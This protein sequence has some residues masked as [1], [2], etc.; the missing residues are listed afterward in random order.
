MQS[1]IVIYEN[2]SLKNAL[3]YFE[4]KVIIIK[5][6]DIMENIYDSAEY[7][8]SRKA[9]IVQCTA[10]YFV[11]ILIAD[12][13]LAKLLSDIGVSDALTGIISSFISF[14]FMFQLLSIGLMK[15]MKSVKKTVILF[16][17]LSQLFFMSVYLVV[18]LPVSQ[19]VKTVLIMAGILF[20]YFGMYLIYSIYFKWANSYVSPDKRG[21]Y[22][23]VKE[24]I[25]LFTGIIFTLGIGFVIDK[26]ESIGNIHGGFLFISV[27]MLLLNVINFISLMAIKDG[28]VQSEG[29][30]VRDIIGNTL[31]N[32]NFNSVV[33]LTVLWEM[34]RYFTIG[35]MG[36]YKTKELALTVGTV[37]IINMAGNLARLVVSKPFGRYSDKK[38]FAKGFNLAFLIAGIGF[39]INI[40]TTPESVWCVV[41]FTVLYAVSM[42]GTNQ[43]SY[44]IIYS[45]VKS[46]Y[47]VEAMSVKNCIGGLMGFFAS[48]IG[49]KILNAVNGAGNTVLGM[50]VYGQQV[51]SLISLIFV[52][53]AMAY[54][55]FVL[56]K[57]KVIKQ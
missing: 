4:L 28:T 5:K 34:A 8:R 55:R 26:Y 11:S 9:Y 22:S 6:G 14:A 3:T 57:V 2:V 17:T 46:D 23:A 43:N 18:F 41:V 12:A 37:Q 44:N 30:S 49:G 52:V 36:V 51:L 45:Y 13:F 47:I 16:D 1:K 31:K 29:H 50:H 38:S 54:N 35:F 19:S 25:S 53:A 33:F 7:K 48:I 39:L 10:E 32:K 21:E 56:Y 42:A 24:M 20:G 15:R 40:F 27:T